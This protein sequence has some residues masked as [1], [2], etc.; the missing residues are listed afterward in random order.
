MFFFFKKVYLFKR[1]R[2]REGVEREQAGEWQRE[3][4]RI[5]DSPLSAEPGVRL[6]LMTL[7]S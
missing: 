7:R 1:E 2:E 6:D 3:R 4:E 5:S